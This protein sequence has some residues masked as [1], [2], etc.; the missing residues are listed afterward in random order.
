MFENINNS[1]LEQ[2]VFYSPSD[3][4]ENEIKSENI[5]VYDDNSEDDDDYI[6]DDD[7]IM[8]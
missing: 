1:N 8:E 4:N 3:T 5:E 2:H 7:E 6:E